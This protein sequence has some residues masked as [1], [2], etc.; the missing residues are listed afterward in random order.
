[1]E[2]R[3]YRLSQLESLDELCSVFQPDWILDLKVGP[4]L[5]DA[6]QSCTPLHL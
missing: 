4:P 1:M 5:L 3:H 2:I 6:Y